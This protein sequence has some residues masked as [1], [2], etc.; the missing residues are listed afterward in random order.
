M[1]NFFNHGLLIQLNDRP[2]DKPSSHCGVRIGGEGTAIVSHWFCERLS[3][4]SSLLF[5]S[6]AALAARMLPQAHAFDS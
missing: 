6:H 2:P 5:F 4:K 1:S 3:G